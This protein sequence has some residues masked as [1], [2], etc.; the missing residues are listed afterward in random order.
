[1]LC[2]PS[3]LRSTT[4]TSVVYDGRRF[5]VRHQINVFFVRGFDALMLWMFELP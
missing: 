1:M 2:S 5:T 3:V 4:R